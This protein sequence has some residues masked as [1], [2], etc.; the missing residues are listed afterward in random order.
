MFADEA[1]EPWRADGVTK[2]VWTPMLERLQLLAVRLYDAR[3]SCA[4]MLLEAGQ[5]MKVVQEILGHASMILT[6][7]TY[8]HVTPAF[9]RQAAD[10][11]AAHLER[12]R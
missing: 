4:T 6:A 9:K 11:L 12:A 7:D 1:G 10:A 5:P 3:H 2:Y 8:S